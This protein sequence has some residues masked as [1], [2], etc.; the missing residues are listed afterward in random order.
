[1]SL[2]VVGCTVV[3]VIIP[4][5]RRLPAWPEHTEFTRDNLVLLRDAPVVTVG[6]NGAN[7][8]YAAARC[9]VGVTLAGNGG[10]DFLGVQAKAWLEQAGCRV[11][12]ST[13]AN[14]TALNL[15]ATNRRLER[16]TFFY[17]GKRVAL[18]A[19]AGGCEAALVCGWPHPPLATVARRFA[20]WRRAGCFT[21]FD[22]G[23]F[24][25]VPPRLAAY[26]EL[27][28]HLDLLIA[29]E[30]ELGALTR[31]DNP[32]DGVRVL[33]R[34]FGGHVVIKR[35]P[36]GARWL[37]AGSD[38]PVDVAGARIRPVNTVGA[39]D[40]FNGALLA[41][42]GRGVDFP[43]ALRFAN[44]VAASAVRSPRGVLGLQAPVL[45]GGR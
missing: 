2:L 16:A 29:N 17:P 28:R 33:R 10:T 8:A 31:A 44:A 21:A 11:L 39:G 25:G 5:L 6:G 40:V 23:P 18:P 37:A 43:A 19:T 38:R 15:T 26:R 42:R 32:A 34:S 36:R 7:A 30:H 41:A 13:V 45:R 24:L 9:G 14:R 12:P 27:F 22:V 3:D 20:A 4:G 1:M 35:G